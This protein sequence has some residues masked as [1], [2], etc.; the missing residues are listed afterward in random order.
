MSTCNNEYANVRRSPPLNGENNIDS[1]AIENIDKNL[2][3]LGMNDSF[4][5][6]ITMAYINSK[7]NILATGGMVLRAIG[8]QRVTVRKDVQKISNLRYEICRSFIHYLCSETW[9]ASSL[10]HEL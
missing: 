7:V 5:F 8:I 10:Q 1:I 6:L 2:K 4:I 3:Q 9:Q